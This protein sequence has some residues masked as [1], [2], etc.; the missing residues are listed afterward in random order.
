[1]F[2]PENGGETSRNLQTS[3]G[4]FSGGYAGYVSF[5]EGSG[6]SIRKNPG[7]S[8]TIHLIGIFLLGRSPLEG[9]VLLKKS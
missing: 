4:L 3:T 2:A 6:I 5:R 8:L 7:K 1:M 9:L